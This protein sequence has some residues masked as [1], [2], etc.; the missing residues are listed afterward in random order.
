MG[1]C[2]QC[3][4]CA[5]WSM[6]SM[7][8]TKVELAAAGWTVPSSIELADLVLGHGHGQ[9]GSASAS[10]VQLIISWQHACSIK[11]GHDDRRGTGGRR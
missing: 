8:W 1:Q 9:G 10:A 4:Q 6:W 7:W 5:V 2:G 3:G 11:R